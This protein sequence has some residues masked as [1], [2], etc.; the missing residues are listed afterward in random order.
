MMCYSRIFAL[1][2]F[3][4]IA[5]F[6]CRHQ[7]V[8]EKQVDIADDGWNEDSLL[9]FNVAINDTVSTHQI[10]FS[11][12]NN[13]DYN[14]ANLFLFASV[15]FPDGK[16]IRD[17]MELIMSDVRG[18]W[19]GSGWLGSYRNDFPYRA[20]IRFPR[21]G[22]YTFR[23]WQAMRSTNKKLPGIESFELKIHK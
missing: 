14:Y 11:V 22:T 17:T 18:E 1:C 7:T 3:A 6:S 23:V 15:T 9:A 20:R 21:V 12:S 4:S 5:L 19:T 13:N 16:S 2:A 10:L 8:F